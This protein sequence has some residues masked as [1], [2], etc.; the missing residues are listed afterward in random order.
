MIQIESQAQDSSSRHVA[1]ILNVAKTYDRLI[2]RGIARYV[3]AVG[4]WSLYVEDEP[5]A[6]IPNLNT[7]R[8]H[9][10]IAD[11][12]DIA[13]AEA[14]S[15]LDIPVVGIGGGFGGYNPDMNIPY[16]ATDNE[17]VAKIAAEHL[18][19]H[20]FQSFA[21]CGYPRTAINVW[22]DL[23]A[24]AFEECIKAAG[25]PCS[26]YRGR[27]RN[28]RRWEALLQG[29]ME[30]ISSLPKPVGLL[31]ANDAR[32]RHVLEAC[33]RLNL[34]VPEDVAVLGVDND[35][36]MC[37]LAMPPLSSVIQGTDRMGY[38][39]AALLDQLMNGQTPEKQRLVIQPVG[40]ATRQSSDVMA[41][42]D[43]LVSQAVRF[44]RQNGNM[45][46][47][48]TDVVK[49]L[50]VSRSTLDARFRALLGRSVHEEI[51]RVQIGHAKDLLINTNLPLKDVAKQSGYNNIQYMT[52]VFR[53]EMNTTP[54]E[55]RKEHSTLN[56]F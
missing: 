16:V 50:N 6:K 12:D 37:E 21:Y 31:A 13:V 48:V 17:A 26:I 40:I 33:R 20:G 53:R 10:I 47:Q 28:P 42:D 1:L 3:K 9:G 46:I 35:E 5:L 45:R 29:L 14:V 22:S 54:G 51:Q 19:V 18:L 43:E 52:M 8:G 2:I 25:Y 30:W 49:R 32:A 38:E 39:A 36:L 4:R 24:D 34:R 11:F 55:F 27:H 44:I 56:T 7:W 23:R 15:N 41:V